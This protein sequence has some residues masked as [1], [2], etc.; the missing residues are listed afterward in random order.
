M[1]LAAL[2]HLQ[3]Q[4]FIDPSVKFHANILINAHVIVFRQVDEKALIC[5]LLKYHFPWITKI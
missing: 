5:V 2:R 3:T 4:V 1:Q